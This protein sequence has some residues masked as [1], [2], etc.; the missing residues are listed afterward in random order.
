MN[1]QVLLRNQWFQLC[2]AAA[3][4]SAGAGIFDLT[5]NPAKNSQPI[6]TPSPAPYSTPHPLASPSP[7]FTQ[8]HA[9][10]AGH[11]IVDV[12]GAADSDSRDL[13]QVVESAAN[14]DTI[15]VRP[16][17]YEARLW[18]K[19]DLIVAGEG[20]APANALLFL[21]RDQ[22]N[23]VH[24]EAGHVTFSNL[25]IEQDFNASFSALDCAMQAHVELTNCSVTSKS[26][27]GVSVQND[28]QL[29]ARDSVFSSSEVGCGIIY[30]GRT[31]GTVTHSRVFGN[32]FGLEVQNQS[33][34]SVDSCTFQYNG[35]QN[36]YGIVT[37]VNGSGA[38][39]E[40][41]R[42]DF[43]QNSA[44]I[45]AQESG[46]LTM[47]GCTLENNG[48][49]L[50]APHFTGG[51]ICVETAAQATLSDLV[52]KFNKQGISVLAAGKAQLNNVSLSD[53]GIATSNTQYINFCSTIYVNGDG[54]TVSISK[55]AISDAIYNGVVVFN[56]A[57]AVV[58]NS[59][60][61]NSKFNG[62]LFGSD[63]GTPGYG[64]VTDSTVF[65]NHVSGI[66]VQSKSS[67]EINGGE[68]SDNFN[69]GVE[70]SGSGSAATLN[71]IYVRNHPKTGM[72]SYTGGMITA[73]HCTIE[74]NQF[75]VQAGLPDTGRESG[76]TI[77]LES[78][79]VQ[80]NTGY[81][82]ISC[83][84]SVINLSGNRFQNGRS[85]YLRESGGIIR[86]VGN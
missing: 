13:N 72:M 20:T 17:R 39:L 11:W 50:E 74:K 19:K 28:A 15:T 2:L 46:S 25:Q 32:K 81:G 59:S 80:S 42:S 23:V 21:N 83:A 75:G 70:V 49:S 8:L 34:V 79:V 76:G 61:S 84:G 66:F 86:N 27:Y 62:V 67:V 22:A 7:V 55:S 43:S 9:K 12:S 14:G 31:H 53:T 78:C 45:Y 6:P 68:L 65:S 69:A 41:V 71:N 57:K 29:D 51:L 82:A 85:D 30:S 77:F 36:G 37:D 16:G 63:D 4:C 3:L 40:V 10:K 73:K 54:T 5:T 52:C 60:I 1:W 35:D 24:I 58:E 64:A 38:T 18:I 26:T 47:T 48:L 56:G 44:G 33:H